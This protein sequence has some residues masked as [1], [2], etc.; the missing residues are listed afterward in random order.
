MG[1]LQQF[2][3]I[4]FHSVGCDEPHQECW[5]SRAYAHTNI[6]SS[7]TVEDK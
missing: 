4:F 2:R 3:L 7:P 1:H 6:L 5:Y